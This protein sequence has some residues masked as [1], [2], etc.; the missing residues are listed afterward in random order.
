M[1]NATRVILDAT[2]NILNTTRVILDAT[3]V[4]L[5]ATRN[6]SKSKSYIKVKYKKQKLVQFT[7]SILKRLDQYDSKQI[8]KGN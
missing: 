1:L 7:I 2:S 5:D 8:A 3:T 6:K 4:I